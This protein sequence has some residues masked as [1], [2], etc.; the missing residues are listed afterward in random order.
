[1]TG[2]TGATHILEHLMFKGSRRFNRESGTEIARVLH[3]V[4]ANFNATTWLDRTSY[5]EVLV[6]HLPLAVDVEPTECR[7]P[8]SRL[9]LERAHRRAQQ[10]EMGRTGRSS[11]S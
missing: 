8:G 5:Y 4:G 2:H 6:E 3:R 7:R 1:V 10:L 9:D 11:C